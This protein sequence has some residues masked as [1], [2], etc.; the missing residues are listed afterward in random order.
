MQDIGTWGVW[1]PTARLDMPALAA[2]AQ[3]LEEL[4]YAALWY[5]EA[6]GWESMSQAAY[7][8]CH[9]SKLLVG[10]SIANIYARDPITARQGHATL[11]AMSRDRFILGL[12]VSHVQIV[13]DARGHTYGKPVATMRDYLTRLRGSGPALSDPAR[14]TVIAA[15]GPKMLEL[16]GE[17]TRGAIPYN[18]TPEHTAQA[19]AILGPD[20]WLCVEQK[21]CLA[22]DAAT[23]RALAAKELARYLPMTNYRNNWLRLGFTEADFENGGTP[24]FL[25]AMVA[26]GDEKA[27][28]ARLQAH[29]GAGADHVAL[30]PVHTDGDMAALDRTVAA[31]APG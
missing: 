26:W 5:P 30:Q 14:T 8:L 1:Y 9:T 25:D 2:F 11:A 18:V 16:A 24:R 15:L 29:L 7:L 31:L 12:G 27:I 21:V 28:H 3:R 13:E 20:K 22:T 4:G 19:R 23:A 6:V 17:L 10:S